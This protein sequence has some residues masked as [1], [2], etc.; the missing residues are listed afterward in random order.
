[1]VTIPKLSLPLFDG[2]TFVIFYRKFLF[3]RGQFHW[4][5]CYHNIVV[6]QESIKQ[7]Y[8]VDITPLYQL[9]H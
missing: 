3:R 4:V 2:Y 9:Q 1:V 7:V 8:W 5:V 6:L